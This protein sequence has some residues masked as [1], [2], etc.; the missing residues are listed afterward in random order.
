MS[1]LVLEDLPEFCRD[2]LYNWE[3]PDPLLR[4]VWVQRILGEETLPLI[5]G[6]W[7]THEENGE[8]VV[9]HCLDFHPIFK[10]DVRNMPPT[11]GGMR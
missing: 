11:G 5:L 2:C 4:C 6:F 7:I 8:E 10:V 9:D 3:Q 1:V